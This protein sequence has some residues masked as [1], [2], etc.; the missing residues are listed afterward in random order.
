YATG[1]VHHVKYLDRQGFLKLYSPLV[2]AMDCFI[3]FLYVV[4]WSSK[5]NS[6]RRCYDI[7]DIWGITRNY[8]GIALKKSKELD[9]FNIIFVM[10]L[11]ITVG[12]EQ[13]YP[14][15]VLKNRYGLFKI[16]ALLFVLAMFSLLGGGSIYMLF[17][18]SEL[19][20]FEWFGKSGFLF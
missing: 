19:I 17:R 16:K 1:K 8:T 13:D 4:Y 18:S 12:I 10:S 15:L 2:L 14:H 11:Y 20:I 5:R 9:L 6:I 7:A 3:G